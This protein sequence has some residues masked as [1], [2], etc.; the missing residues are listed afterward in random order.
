MF[1]NSRYIIEFYKPK[2]EVLAT[3]DRGLAK[4]FLDWDKSF[5][6]RVTSNGF[7]LKYSNWNASPDIRGDFKKDEEGRDNLWLAIS[8]GP[9]SWLGLT[10][11]ALIFLTAF[12]FTLSLGNYLW[13]FLS[14]F[15]AFYIQYIRIQWISC[16]DE[17]LQ[18][19]KRSDRLCTISP[20]NN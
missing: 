8:L 2:E 10:V 3:I 20:L 5:T 4:K 15:Y 18:L 13:F 9:L 11:S 17:F 7:R 14:V 16:K 12:V 19:L 6:G 1:L